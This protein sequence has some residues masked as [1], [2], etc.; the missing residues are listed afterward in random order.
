MENNVSKDKE[1]LCP[2]SRPQVK[3]SKV[4]GL[5]NGT[6]EKPRVTYLKSSQPVTNEL[7]ALAQ[8]VT[9]TEV[10]RIAAPCAANG[11]RHFDGA[12]CNIATKLVSEFSVVEKDLPSCSIRQ[13]C[14]WYQQEGQSACLRCSQVI[15]DN[16]NS[17]NL[18]SEVVS[19]I[20]E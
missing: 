6:V 7:I 12:N 15:T 20:S 19:S 2:S 8:P 13:D 5:V 18:T 11:C 3:D 1:M 4:F 10:F 9:A 16:Y 14:R 17:N